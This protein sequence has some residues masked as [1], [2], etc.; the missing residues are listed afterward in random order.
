M[1]LAVRSARLLGLGGWRQRKHLLRTVKKELRA[2]NKIAKGKGRD[3]P[4]RLQDGY[5]T[6]LDLADRILAEAGV[7]RPRSDLHRSQ[8]RCVQNKH[9]Q[10]EID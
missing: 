6:L 10:G 7:A 5:R 1:P 8:H 3:F 4:K 2:I 9:A